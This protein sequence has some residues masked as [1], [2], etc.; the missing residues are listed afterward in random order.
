MRQI[1]W[2][3]HGNCIITISHGRDLRERDD[4]AKTMKIQV[5]YTTDP[6]ALH[7]MIDWNERSGV[8]TFPSMISND[9]FYA[10]NFTHTDLQ[11]KF[12]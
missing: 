10:T 6:W 4:K 5:S 9:L 8:R 12:A 1:G 2:R 7:F 11:W 3:N